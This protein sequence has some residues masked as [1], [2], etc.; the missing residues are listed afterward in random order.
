MRLNLMEKTALLLLPALFVVV[1]GVQADSGDDYAKA[2]KKG[3]QLAENIQ[4]YE[5][6]SNLVMENKVKGQESGMKLEATQ[7]ARCSMPDRLFI[8]IESPQFQQHWGTGPLE[9]WFSL[10]AAGSCYVGSPL[11][12]TREMKNDGPMELTND[13]IFN[14]FA[15]LS[16]FIFTDEREAEG[17]TVHET[18]MVGEKEIPCQVFS[19]SD[20]NG[21]R[22]FWYDPESGLILRTRL[23]TNITEQGTVMERVLHT[24]VTSFGLDLKLDDSQFTFATPAGLRVV[25]TLERV[26]NPDSMVGLPA[27][28]IVF[29]DLNGQTTS[30][31]DYRGKVVFIDFW[32]TWCGPCRMEMPHIEK[33][34]QEFKA[35][36]DLVII[37]ASNE[38]KGTVGSFLQKN[39]FSFPIVLVNPQDSQGKFKVTSI[40]AGFVIDREG[41]IRAHMIGM[42]NEDQLR[43]AFLKG[44]FEH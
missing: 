26:M 24:Q 39:K 31:S 16:D 43:A 21:N 8:A 1:G 20:E 18:V 29:T 27:P 4:S 5:I 33:L 23:V 38:N 41:I 14:F 19:F 44:G 42:Q 37:G 17:E 7:T 40:P 28:E 15:G 2:L 11:Q 22:R 10:P 3:Q 13:R 30:L 35:N 34:Y 25:N 9:S 12:L 6:I 36:G 32:A